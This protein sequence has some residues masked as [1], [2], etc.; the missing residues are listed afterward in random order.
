M[1]CSRY[2]AHKYPHATDEAKVAYV[3]SCFRRLDG[4]LGLNVSGKD[5]QARTPRTEKARTEGL[6]RGRGQ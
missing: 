1:N 3:V 2:Q 5:G 4:T 6:V